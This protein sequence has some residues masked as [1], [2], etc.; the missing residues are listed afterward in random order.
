MNCPT[1]MK[2]EMPMSWFCSQEC[3]KS[4][5]KTHNK[6]HKAQKQ[7]IKSMRA[8]KPPPFDYTGPLKPYYVSPMRSVPPETLKPDYYL[9]GLPTSEMAR[10]RDTAIEIKS[11]S[12]IAKMRKVCRVR[13]M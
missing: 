3:F 6:L 5:W 9:D 2:L 1:C 4:Y 13:H 8:F 11:K 10:K 12:Q 7:L